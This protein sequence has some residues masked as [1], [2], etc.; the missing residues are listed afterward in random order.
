LTRVGQT[1]GHLSGNC[2][3]TVDVISHEDILKAWK[4]EYETKAVD[5]TRFEGTEFKNAQD[6]MQLSVEYR[7][8]DLRRRYSIAPL[9]TDI[10][11]PLGPVTLTIVFEMFG[12][13]GVEGKIQ[14][15][16]SYGRDLQGVALD[17]IAPI[18]SFLENER[19]EVKAIAG[20]VIEP[21]LAL[22]TMVF[23]GAGVPGVSIGLEGQLDLLNVRLPGDIRGIAMVG[24]TPDTR[25]VASSPWAGDKFEG[26]PEERQMNMHWGFGTGL[27]AVMSALNGKL[28][29]A[30]RIRLLFFKK[31]IRKTITSWKGI[32]KDFLLYGYETGA[33]L[34]EAGQFGKHADRIL[35]RKPNDLSPDVDLPIPA[36][37]DFFRDVLGYEDCSEVVE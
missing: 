21:H 12:T 9:G 28:S 7:P 18:A 26:F 29:A 33:T 24:S 19:P 3:G 2:D 32:N 37:T 10:T 23:A 27:R 17:A 35:Y 15:G 31:T 34:T 22:S 25:D 14:A 6:R 20:P 8:L 1:G 30:L 36:A 13:W 11:I 16:L 5:W 4:K